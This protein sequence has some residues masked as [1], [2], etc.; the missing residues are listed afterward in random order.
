MCVFDVRLYQNKLYN[1]VGYRF[2]FQSVT[3]K[4][5]IKKDYK[6]DANEISAEQACF[7]CQD[8]AGRYLKGICPSNYQA[9]MIHVSVLTKLSHFSTFVT[10]TDWKTFW[11][12]TVREVS[13]NGPGISGPVLI[14]DAC[15]ATADSVT[16]SE[17]R[18]VS[19]KQLGEAESI[20][21]EKERKKSV[22]LGRPYASAS[23]SEDEAFCV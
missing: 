12:V 5:S 3:Q 11:N 7:L 4:T 23:A 1:T 17:L 14:F 2:A 22:L 8:G 21:L 9:E 19:P 18:S 15:A 6:V 20:T 16:S 13:L 10:H